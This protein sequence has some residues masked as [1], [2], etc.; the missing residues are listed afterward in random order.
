M[1]FGETGETD[2]DETSRT[3]FI[4]KNSKIFSKFPI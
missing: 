3:N 1:K 2:F 4:L